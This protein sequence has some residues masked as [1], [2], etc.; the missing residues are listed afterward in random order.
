MVAE[1]F[2]GLGALKSAF[3]LARGLKDIGNATRRISAAGVGVE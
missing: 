3:D 1:V 2:A